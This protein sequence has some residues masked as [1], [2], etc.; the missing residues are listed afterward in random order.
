MTTMVMSTSD[1]EITIIRW[2]PSLAHAGIGRPNIPGFPGLVGVHCAV[3]NLLLTSSCPSDGC[4]GVARRPA[5]RK[6]V[7]GLIRR[8]FN[9]DK[10]SA[11]SACS[12]LITSSKIRCYQNT[13]PK[14]MSRSIV[15]RG[16]FPLI[17]GRFMHLWPF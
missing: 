2:H 11:C 16:V 14:E 13:L 5:C 1:K 7:L 4:G 9:P 8:L 12:A 17:W 6:T 3:A 10:I 15:F